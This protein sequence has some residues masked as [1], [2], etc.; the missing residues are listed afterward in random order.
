MNSNIN[1][2]TKQVTSIMFKTTQIAV[3]YLNLNELF[4]L[5]D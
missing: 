2:V 4:K 1:I 3:L 5:C